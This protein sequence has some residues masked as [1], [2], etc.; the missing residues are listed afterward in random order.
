MEK[1]K[2]VKYLS[3]FKNWTQWKIANKI[4][5]S[6]GCVGGVLTGRN[7]N[8]NNLSK[9]EIRENFLNEFKQGKI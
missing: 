4:G 1:R 8:F 9:E 7:Y 5:V 3:Y 2:E 6:S